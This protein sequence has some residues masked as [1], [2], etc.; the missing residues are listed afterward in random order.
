MAYVRTFC[1]NQPTKDG[2]VN[3][4]W[5]AG[6][7]L[8]I[9]GTGVKVDLP[10]QMHEKIEVTLGRVIF[11]LGIFFNRKK[12]GATFQEELRFEVKL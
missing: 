8:H 12:N 9:P 5:Q 10:V 4:S 6:P 2:K 3:K 1:L 11:E 7:L